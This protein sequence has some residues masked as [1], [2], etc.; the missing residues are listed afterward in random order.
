M[1][2]MIKFLETRVVFTLQAMVVFWAMFFLS[3]FLLAQ[4][5]Q[6][7][8]T[9]RSSSV[10]LIAPPVNDS[11]TFL[12]FAD[13]TD[14]RPED[15]SILKDAVIDA[16]RL[17]PDFVMNIGDM[18]QGYNA[19]EQ[20]LEQM[21]EYKTVMNELKCPWFP[22]AGNHDIYARRF[23][24]GLPKKQHEK[25]YE[26][27]F[28][29]LWYAFEY[30]NYWFIALFTDEGNPETE[31]KSFGKPECQV[32]SETQ[33]RW[34]KSILQKAKNADGIF[35]FQ[36]HPRW[37][38]GGYGDDWNK[39]HTAFVETGKVK[40]VFAGHIHRMTY[41]EKDGIK[42]ITLATTGGKLGRI[43]SAVG[44]IQEIHHVSLKKNKEPEIT[45]LPVK[46]TLDVT[47]MPSSMNNKPKTDTPKNKTTKKPQEEKTF[48]GTVL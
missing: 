17:A 20:W 13:R 23:A 8:E 42:Y 33:F 43:D 1:T 24:K 18:V 2:K 10:K 7:V 3:P 30:K 22:V 37:F 6:S 26:E 40:A 29:P 47:A 38:G 25:E 32:M 19:T 44:L 12:I 15:I 46:T 41:N 11:F 39:V 36:H 35:V 28:G 9:S 31:E 14:G 34:L 21:K 27:N 45:I 48:S 4:L 5:Q 16:N